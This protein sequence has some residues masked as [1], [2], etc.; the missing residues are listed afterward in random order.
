MGQCLSSLK[1]GDKALIIYSQTEVSQGSDR[2]KNLFCSELF[3]KRAAGHNNTL[4]RR[5]TYIC[6]VRCVIHEQ[7]Q[8]ARFSFLGNLFFPQL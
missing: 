5:V 4:K 7:I 8:L 2:L 1:Y 6:E 3:E